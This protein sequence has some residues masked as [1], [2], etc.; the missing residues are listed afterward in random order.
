M[1]ED[2]TEE[3]KTEAAA[4]AAGIPTKDQIDA[5]VKSQLR[6]AEAG[7]TLVFLS[8]QAQQMITS[9]TGGNT[10]LAL[11]VVN[12]L[13]LFYKEVLIRSIEIN[14]VKKTAPAPAPAEGAAEGAAEDTGAA[15]AA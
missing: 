7:G 3:Q 6:I 2:Q 11:A 14:T 9:M 4:A 15:N 10:R 13:Q 5:L 12:E 8:G 1:A